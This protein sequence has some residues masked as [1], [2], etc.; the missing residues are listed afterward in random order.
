MGEQDPFSGVVTA[1][2]VYAAVVNVGERVG[3]VDH[4]VDLVDNKVVA[5]D[6]KVDGV[7]SSV[8]DLQARVRELESIDTRQETAIETSVADVADLQSRVR[9]LEAN[10]WPRGL[11]T[12]LAFASLVIALAALWR[13]WS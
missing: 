8:A 13:G 7:V 5:V 1:A 2:T 12:V 6:Q 10:R 4:K 9:D 3:Q 11:P